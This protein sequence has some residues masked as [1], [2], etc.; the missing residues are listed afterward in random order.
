MK[1]CLYGNKKFSFE[2]TANV[3][4]IFKVSIIYTPNFIIYFI[5]L[6][7]VLFFVI[8]YWNCVISYF[9]LM[10]VLLY[11]MNQLCLYIVIVVRGTWIVEY[12]IQ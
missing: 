2:C 11:R 7:F 5:F 1:K 4:T 12:E 10:L 3:F 6:N 9:I 8:H